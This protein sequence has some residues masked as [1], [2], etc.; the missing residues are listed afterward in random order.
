[1]PNTPDPVSVKL[2]NPRTGGFFLNIRETATD[3]TTL[4]FFSD[5][6][7]LLVTCAATTDRPATSSAGSVNS[8]RLRG[9]DHAASVCCPGTPLA[10]N[11]PPR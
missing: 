1:M 10:L 2:W 4:S 5:G 9:Q 7:V 3:P 6:E 8:M 11:G